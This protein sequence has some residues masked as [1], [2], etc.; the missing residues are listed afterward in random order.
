MKRI[1]AKYK[2]RKQQ[3]QQGSILI[4]ALVT[5]IVLSMSIAAIV[6]ITINSYAATERKTELQND[7][8]LGEVKIRQAMYEFETYM[9]TNKDFNML[10]FNEIPRILTDYGI[11]VTNVTGTAG[12][13]Q[14][15]VTVD[16]ESRAYKFEYP[17]VATGQ[18]LVMYSYISTVGSIVAGITQYDFSIASN[19]YVV[20][21]SGFIDESSLFGN[22]IHFGKSSPFINDY[23]TAAETISEVNGSYPDFTNPDWTSDVY[24]SNEYTYCVSTCFNVGPTIADDFV[25]QESEFVDIE[26]SSLEMGTLYR[27]YVTDDFFSSYDLATEI[28]D[29]VANDG[30]NGLDSFVPTS[31]TSLATLGSDVLTNSAVG[32]T[33]QPYTDVT[34]VI[35]PENVAVTLG[36]A[37][38]YNGNLI[39]NNDFTITNDSTE[40]LVVI[41]NL[42]FENTTNIDVTGLIVVLGDLTFSGHSVAVDGGF[43]VTGETTFDFTELYGIQDVGGQLSNGFT[44]LSIDNVYVN[45]LWE[46]HTT[47]NRPAVWDWLVYTEE[48]IYIDAV[49]SRININGGL[50][51]AARDNSGNYIPIVD[52][53]AQ[54]ILGIVID[55]FRGYISNT[56]GGEVPTS[57]ANR[58]RFYLN[59]MTEAE[60]QSTFFQYP[61]FATLELAKEGPF[62][63]R[64]AFSIE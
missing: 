11:V 23:N 56:N 44:L 64:S 55:A 13:T 24:F 10:D 39:I 38:V 42:T 31:T 41:G 28:I 16:G 4:I 9:F 2:N 50:Y 12:F 58:N 32:N 63:E 22:D 1:I 46:I 36:S 43:L 29:F 60:I 33:S 3:K 7:Q 20:I 45:S 14:F 47:S 19:G 34:G 30:P 59:V 8:A 25:L 51:A 5:M 54:P 6:Q 62:F 26:G 48:S 61:V 21:N 35:D 15:G 18:T 27:N 57:S 53:S 17:L 40:T 49:N 37:G 52:E